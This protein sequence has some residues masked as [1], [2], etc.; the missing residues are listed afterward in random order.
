MKIT[1]DGTQIDVIKEDKNIVDVLDR[2]KIGI[3]AACYR[4]DQKTGCCRACVIEI[5]GEQKY[6]CSTVP[7]D[8]ME[9]VLDRADLKELRKER[10]MK[11]NEGMESCDSCEC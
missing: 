1:I 7:E 9:I 4:A 8:K 11:Y 6:A 2:M 3:S 5:G 10:L